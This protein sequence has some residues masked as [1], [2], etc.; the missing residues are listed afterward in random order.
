MEGSNSNK[1][2]LRIILLSFL[3]F[4]VLGVIYYGLSLYGRKVVYASDSTQ[5]KYP[6]SGEMISLLDERVLVH[7]FD[8]RP[9]F[10]PVG[11]KSKYADKPNQYE[12]I[13]IESEEYVS[14]T[15]GKFAG[16]EEV[17][18]SSDKYLLVRYPTL[19]RGVT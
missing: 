13:D 6:G 8:G 11:L 3:V 14:Y 19:H 5:S 4:S 9:F 7:P 18:G 1:I 16:W 12:V 2:Y 17:S 15:V 10:V